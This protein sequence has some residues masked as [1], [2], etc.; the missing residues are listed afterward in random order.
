MV[1]NKIPK[2]E[3]LKTV[4]QVEDPDRK[5]AGCAERSGAQSEANQQNEVVAACLQLL[6]WLFLMIH[7]K[8]EKSVCTFLAKT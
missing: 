5:L 1:S 3:L 8:S 7:R 4:F 6:I 2:K